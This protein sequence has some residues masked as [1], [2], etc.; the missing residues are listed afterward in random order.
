MF[1]TALLAVALAAPV[2]KEKAKA[3]YWPRRAGDKWVYDQDRDEVSEEVAK[4]TEKDGETRVTTKY[5]AGPGNSWEVEYVV[6][7]GAVYQAKSGPFTFDP[8]VRELELDLKAG[9][10]W[11]SKTPLTQGVIGSGGEMVAGEEE[12]VTVP[13]G[14][15]KAIPVVYTVTEVDGKP[16]PKP[17]V[18]TYWYTAGVGL[19]KL[20]YEGVEKVLKAFTPGP[21]A[22]K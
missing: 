12:E 22:K 6:K 16:I 1:L 15:Y 18:Y 7:G 3:D 4:V 14:T 17:T 9:A 10:K 11:G 20:K 21:Q 19:V 5:T 8:P 2:P 13:A